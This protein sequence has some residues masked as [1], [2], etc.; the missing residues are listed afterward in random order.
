M[1]IRGS[2][3]EMK[4]IYCDMCK[5]HPVATVK[6]VAFGVWKGVCNACR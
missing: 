2:A 5:Q 6:E 1:S 3:A 4:V